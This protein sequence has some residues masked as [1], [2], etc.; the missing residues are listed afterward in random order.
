[1][2]EQKLFEISIA[3]LNTLHHFLSLCGGRRQVIG[4]A[5]E[6]PETLPEGKEMVMERQ[7]YIGL[8]KGICSQ[9]FAK[10]RQRRLVK[11]QSLHRP[12]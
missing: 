2:C 3:T 9:P 7:K 11:L 4:R 6:L 1:M 12:K 5:I 8:P 10:W